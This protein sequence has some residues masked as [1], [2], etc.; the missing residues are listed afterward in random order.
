MTFN[1]QF[2]E[3]LLKDKSFSIHPQN[4]EKLLI[5]IR[6][7]L[8]NILTNVYGDLFIRNTHKLVVIRQKSES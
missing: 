6:R 8:Y 5:E 7:T 3:V 1:L 4:I 2:E